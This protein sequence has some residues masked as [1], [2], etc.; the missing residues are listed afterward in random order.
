MRRES[1]RTLG[2]AALLFA[3]NAYITLPLFHTDYTRQMGSIEA[4]YIGLA[5]YAS[6]HWN[7]M[8]WF[9]L[10]YGG[11]PFLDG[12]APLRKPRVRFHR[13]PRLLADLARL[14]PGPRGALRRR[15]ILRRP[16]PAHA[17]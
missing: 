8:G 3:L 5:R 11:I 1:A 6:Q 13:R 7:D 12:V 2:C 10:W 15:R 9:P 17:G 14:P 16:P 4:A